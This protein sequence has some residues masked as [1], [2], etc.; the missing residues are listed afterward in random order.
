MSSNYAKA[1]NFSQQ[2]LPEFIK[3]NGLLL[4][5][6]FISQKDIRKFLK[7]LTYR[8]INHWSEKGLVA[9]TRNN[10]K[11]GWRKFSLLDVIKLQIISDL[12]KFSCS[13][14]TI[15]I[16]LNNLEKCYFTHLK[17]KKQSTNKSLEFFIFSAMLGKKNF[18]MV[19]KDGNIS[20][21]NHQELKNNLLNDRMPLF[22]CILPFYLYAVNIANAAGFKVKSNKTNTFEH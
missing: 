19:E 3:K 5:V 10:V 11:S 20:F 13:L 17:D 12:R 16:I 18:L 2:E 22:Y 21:L 6:G 9:A 14:K 7:D 1:F 8:Q 4:H 15:K